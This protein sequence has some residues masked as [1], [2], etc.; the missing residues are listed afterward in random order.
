[1]LAATG[2]GL[3]RRKLW[4][5][6]TATAAGTLLVCD[7]WFDTLSSRPDGERLLAVLLAVGVELPAAAV[8]LLIA[9]HAEELA[10][11]TQRYALAAHRL[12]PWRRLARGSGA[13]APGEGLLS[14]FRT[15]NW[16]RRSRR[17]SVS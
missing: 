12:R 17:G 6:S 16:P 2:Y 1:V 14:S 4:V 8:C 9:S 13:E 5:Q 10:E 7:A 11:R 3:L 15:S